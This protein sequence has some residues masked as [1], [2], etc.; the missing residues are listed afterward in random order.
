MVLTADHIAAIAASAIQAAGLTPNKQRFSDNLFADNINPAT[1][2][3]LAL[4]NTATA[5]VPTEKRIGMKK[6]W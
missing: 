1:K 6:K 5:A 3:G 4:F 2:T